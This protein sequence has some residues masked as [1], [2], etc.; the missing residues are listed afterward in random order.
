MRNALVCAG[1]ERSLRKPLS[2]GAGL[3]LTCLLT[4]AIGFCQN[5]VSEQP[6]AT[7]VQNNPH[8]V[9][10]V[11]N[12]NGTSPSNLGGAAS[13][14]PSARNQ[15]LP[16]DSNPANAAAEGGKN[17]KAVTPQSPNSG[18]PGTAS[19]NSASDVPNGNDRSLIGGK[20][21]KNARPVWTASPVL[22]IFL[23]I[24][25]AIILISAL[26]R[27]RRPS[28]TSRVVTID[29]HIKSR[30]ERNRRIG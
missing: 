27:P 26:A 24:V 21:E 15:A 6:P 28:R 30:D 25:V 3:V 4:V 17:G 29:D 16:G 2:T 5:P 8:S 18:V 23:G 19:G 11:P 14:T 1:F 10:S 9:A 22:W 20:P 12:S 7:G 13:Q